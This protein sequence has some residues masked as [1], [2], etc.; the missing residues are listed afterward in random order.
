[1]IRVTFSTSV[2]KHWPFVCIITHDGAI[3]G[4]EGAL[5]R[6]GRSAALAFALGQARSYFKFARR[7]SSPGPGTVP[8]APDLAPGG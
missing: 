1:M 8:G 7:C 2:N 4:C 5:T 3:V 6:K